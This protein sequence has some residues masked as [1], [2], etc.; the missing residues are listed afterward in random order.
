M[1]RR[2]RWTNDDVNFGYGQGVEIKP[3]LYDLDGHLK[4]FFDEVD[5]RRLLAS[6]WEQVALHPFTV[7]RF[8]R[9]KRVWAAAGRR[10][11]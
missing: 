9:P 8:G 1:A 5:G 2:W 4:R 11:G 7:T 6:G 3:G 10:S